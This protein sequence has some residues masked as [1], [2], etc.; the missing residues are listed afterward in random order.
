MNDAGARAPGPRSCVTRTRFRYVGPQRDRISG[1][2][3][4]ACVAYVGVD[5]VDR[6]C[7]NFKVRAQCDKKV[8]RSTHISNINKGSGKAAHRKEGDA[9]GPNTPQ[10]L[11]ARGNITAVDRNLDTVGA[12]PTSRLQHTLVQVGNAEE[13][14]DLG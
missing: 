7:V 3:D 6:A 2:F 13:A 14:C 12:D 9:L 4:M 11:R 8:D 10:H 1:E 5:C